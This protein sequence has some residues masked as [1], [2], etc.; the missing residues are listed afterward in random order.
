M[1]SVICRIV[2]ARLSPRKE[3]GLRCYAHFYENVMLSS[4]MVPNS[5]P[6][7]LLHWNKKFVKK[8]NPSVKIIDNVWGIFVGGIRLNL[9]KFGT[10]AYVLHEETAGFR[11]DS[12]RKK[13]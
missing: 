11:L 1:N 6:I 8:K 9:Q 10:W 3:L 5:I 13:G 2:I 7:S 12:I 4:K